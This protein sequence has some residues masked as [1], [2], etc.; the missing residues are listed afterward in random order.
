MIEGE[1]MKVQIEDNLFIESDGIQYV[2][3]EYS[4]T[5][6][7][8]KDGKEIENFKALGYY[9]T[10]NQ[11]VKSL[12]QM[13]IKKSTADNLQELTAD[14]ERIHKDIDEKINA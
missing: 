6:H 13:K 14:I 12:L 3:K 2:L 7:T 5:T 8:N 1:D 11:V 10:I 9:G 4:G